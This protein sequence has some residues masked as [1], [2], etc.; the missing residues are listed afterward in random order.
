MRRAIAEALV[1]DEQKRE[2][3]TVN[4]LQKRVAALLGQEAA[5][6][7]PTATMA[8]QI[9]LKLL[10][11]PGEVLLAEEHSHVVI[12]EYGGPA[13]HAGLMTL[14]LRG[15]RG[16]VTS[17]QVRR[18]AEPSTK[19]ADQRATVLSLENTH[20]SSGGRVW[21]LGELDEVVT[22]AREVGLAVHLDGARLVNA[23]VA[24]GV[25]P[26]DI[27]ARFDTVTLCLSK[28]LGCPLGALLA[29]SEELMERAWREKHLMGGAM[30]QAGVVAAAG[31]YALDHNV[32]RIAEDHARARALG[33]ALHGAG[34]TVDL[35]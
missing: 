5:I 23:A 4:E 8:N 26:S 20:N 16:R 24:I 15:A 22:T 28:G 17:E 2:D 30:R 18:A 3:P 7:V 10:S 13:A 12:Y 33:E 29:G 27:A 19:V 6:F 21:P 31:V 25:P 11:R 9:A 1:G 14:A 35:E 32:E 34:L